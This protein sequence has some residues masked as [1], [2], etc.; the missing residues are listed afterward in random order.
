MKFDVVMKQFKLNI[1]EIYWMREINA[2]LLTASKTS[3]WHAFGQLCII[4]V[5][6][7]DDTMTDTT[8][9]YILI[10]VY[11]TFTLNELCQLS[12]KAANGIQ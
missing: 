4:L 6:M 5:L 2:V 1:N 10:L 9:L 8:A 12:P 3:H 7:Y 11:V